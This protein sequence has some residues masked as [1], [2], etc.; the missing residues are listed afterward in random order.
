MLLSTAQFGDVEYEPSDVI[1]FP[2]G[3]PGFEEQRTFIIIPSGDVEF[4]FNT[5]HSTENESLAFIVTDPFLFV[6]NYDFELSQNDADLLKISGEDDL[7]DVLALSIVTIPEN[8]ENTTINIMAPLMIN[9]KE[10]IGKQI[11]LNEYDEVKYAIFK[12]TSEE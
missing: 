6:E 3:I 4:P 8:V 2:Q 5:L 12:K 10:K 11:L 1:T 7:E 9:N